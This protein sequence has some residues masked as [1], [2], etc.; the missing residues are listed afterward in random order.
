M[1]EQICREITQFSKRPCS[2]IEEHPLKSIVYTVALNIIALWTAPYSGLISAGF[3]FLS[4]WANLAVVY[5]YDIILPALGNAADGL[6]STILP[7]RAE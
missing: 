5:K 2:F 6:I 1:L 4:V 3:Y 7:R